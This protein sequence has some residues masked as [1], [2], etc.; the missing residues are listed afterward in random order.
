MS[1]KSSELIAE[2]RKNGD[3][4]IRMVVGDAIDISD[5]REDYRDVLK[6]FNRGM[7]S[8]KQKERESGPCIKGVSKVCMSVQEEALELHQAL[9]QTGWENVF[10]DTLKGDSREKSIE[11]LKKFRA[12]YENCE[13]GGYKFSRNVERSQEVYKFL[14]YKLV[15]D[16]L[17][18]GLEQLEN[19]FYKTAQRVRN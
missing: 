16:R 3:I 13:S 4:E 18:M 19:R 14:M 5:L 12:N 11:G 6:S 17:S 7:R 1:F 15:A 9:L 2:N 10:K 8:Q